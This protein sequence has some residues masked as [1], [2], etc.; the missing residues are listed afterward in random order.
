MPL[1]GWSIADVVS[2]FRQPEIAKLLVVAS[3]KKI[4]FF[5][6]ER[7]T[8]VCPARPEQFGADYP[9]NRIKTLPALPSLPASIAASRKFSA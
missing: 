9:L 7:I 3:T 2:G 4:C 6:L 1:G 8:S 5:M